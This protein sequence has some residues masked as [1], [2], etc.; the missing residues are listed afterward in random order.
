MTIAT[1]DLLNVADTVAREKGIER[2]QVLHAMEE[3]IQKIGRTT[4]GQ[5][6][7]I[8]AEINRKTGDISLAHY[9]HV[10]ESI[11]NPEL[12]I[13]LPEALTLNPS[14]EIG[15]FLV[16]P[17]PPVEFG[18]TAAQ[19]ARQIISQRVREAEKLR[20]YEEFKDKAGEIVSGL[21]KRAEFGNYIIE[22]G[23]RNECMLRRE[24]SIPREI[25]RPGDRVRAYVMDVVEDMRGPQVLLS[26]SHPQF[27]AKLF[28]QE[29][30][31]IYE[32][33]I[34]VVSVARDPGSR[35]KIA[36]RS[37]DSSLDPVGACV[38]IRGSRVQAVINELQGEK[39]DIVPWSKEVPTFIIS[40]LAPATIS[41]VVYDE[42]SRRVEVV[43]P[44][45]QLS[46]AIGRRGQNVRLA[47][48]LTG[49]EISIMSES[50]D[51]KKV[52]NTFKR[53]AKMFM[54]ELDV[55]EV[56]AHLLIAEGY[57]SVEDVAESTLTELLDIE[58]FEEE[59]VQ[60]LQGRAQKSL[61]KK[62]KAV[63]QQLEQLEIEDDLLN[64]PGLTPAL[65]IKMG[66]AGCRSLDDFADLSSDELL[67]IVGEDALTHET[68][69]DLIMK[70]RSHW[71]DEDGNLKE[72]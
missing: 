59:L 32:G 62:A 66:E 40:A 24:E 42:E 33:T 53:T 37:R 69:T 1:N 9:R 14:L 55:D 12:Q 67:E 70:A 52:A 4:Y 49:L 11:E 48:L 61:D 8:R 34:E 43:V 23:G 64:L 3:A 57:E 28:Q 19:M 41:K 18:R 7:D 47:S 25:L 10:V 71:F 35:A 72:A 15:Q 54:E 26:R 17:L 38:G 22:V 44:D 5:D 2:E 60:E 56:I 51:Y 29:V 21:I 31:E 39:I 50:D 63:T 30:P 46:I 13:T 20:Q 58:G 65:L 68:A 45:D 36:V 27:M 16:Q 6:K